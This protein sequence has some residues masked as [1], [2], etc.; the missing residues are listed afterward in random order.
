MSTSCCIGVR[1]CWRDLRGLRDVGF[2]VACLVGAVVFLLEVE[3][4]V[5][6]EIVGVRLCWSDAVGAWGGRG[7]RCEP[8]AAGLSRW[9]YPPRALSRASSCLPVNY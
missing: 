6:V 9:R 1:L 4:P 7:C 8:F 2:G 5:G 3:V